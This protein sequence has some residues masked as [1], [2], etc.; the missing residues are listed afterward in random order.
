VRGR[1]GGGKDENPGKEGKLR[2]EG[3]R[4][5]P[6]NKWGTT[7]GGRKNSVRGSRHKGEAREKERFKG[8]KKKEIRIQSGLAGKRNASRVGFY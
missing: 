5:S 1:T 6:A 3:G 8:E 7:I 4:S 2:G